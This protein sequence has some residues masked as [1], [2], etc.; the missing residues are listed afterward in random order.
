M[1]VWML[2]C[3][4]Q[5]RYKHKTTIQYWK[6]EGRNKLTDEHKSVNRS[7]CRKSNVENEWWCEPVRR[8]TEQFWL[9]RRECAEI[10]CRVN[11][12]SCHWWGA[13]VWMNLCWSSIRTFRDELKWKLCCGSFVLHDFTVFII[14]AR[15]PSA[16][17]LHFLSFH[18]S[19]NHTVSFSGKVATGCKIPLFK[20]KKQ[21]KMKKH[22]LWRWNL[23]F[24]DMFC[25]RFPYHDF[26]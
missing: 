26:T 14:Y 1:R 7:H 22:K 15:I 3:H 21:K 19:L 5:K 25:L 4:F 13:D 24:S 17:F 12:S 10:T 23:T 20:E 2:D 11:P 18:L 9:V 8:R 16:M 6:G